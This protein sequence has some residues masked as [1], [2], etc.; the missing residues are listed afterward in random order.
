MSNA[1]AL[2]KAHNY[3]RCLHGHPALQ[4]DDAVAKNAQ[5]PAD[6]SCDAGDLMHS[7]S[8]DMKPPAGENL[9]IGLAAPERATAAWYNELLDPGYSA[10]DWGSDAIAAG[11]G[12]YTAMI[13]NATKK[14]GCASCVSAGP[15][16]AR[17]VWA[18]QYAEE[19]PNS[20]TQPDW[21]KNVPQSDELEE[22]PE[23]CC[24]QIYS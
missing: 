2:V 19:A 21:E 22:T 16:A 24:K 4:W 18:C 20:G 23:T 10:G 17:T 13:W 1:D 6:Q 8:Y 9:A 11:V 14:L 7:D 12:H 15:G 5:H 3:L